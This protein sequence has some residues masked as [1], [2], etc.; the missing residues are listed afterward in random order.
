MVHIIT[1]CIL[2]Y[3]PVL[4]YTRVTVITQY[5]IALLKRFC[6]SL[7]C[8]LGLTN[9]F[10]KCAALSPTL[11]TEALCSR[12]NSVTTLLSKAQFQILILLSSRNKAY[13]AHV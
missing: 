5:Y 4:C 2:K 6:I 8:H 12:R 7:N 13:L 10:K 1:D 3:F 11:P 9:Q